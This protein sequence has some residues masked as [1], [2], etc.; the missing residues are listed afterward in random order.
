MSYNIAIDGPSGAGKSVLAKKLA[1]KLGFKYVDT[2]AIYRSVG[3]YMYEHG[4]DVSD[5][6]AVEDALENV[7]IRL[8]YSCGGQQ[9]LVNGVDYGDK[10][11]LPE[12]SMYASAVAAIPAVRKKLLDVQR[13]AAKNHD[14]VMDGR[15][16]GTVI[17]P[18]ADVKIFLSASLESRAHRRW[19]EL[20]EKGVETTFE[21]VRADMQRRDHQD[22]TRAQ[23]PCVPAADAVLLDNTNM[24]PDETLEAALEIVRAKLG[25]LVK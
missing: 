8:D 23:A 21:E 9:V 20:L 25:E 19:L 11:R 17:L 24:P 14:T 7:D 5:A 4:I 1:R 6:S 22:S 18:D 10:I 2:G 16:I 12:I 13:E 15:D 3:Y